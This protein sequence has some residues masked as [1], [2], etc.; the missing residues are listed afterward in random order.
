MS[1]LKLD[2]NSK[3]LIIGIKYNIPFSFSKI[4]KNIFNIVDYYDHYDTITW[5]VIQN[6]NN[7]ENIIYYYIYTIDNIYI[8][9]SKIKN[10]LKNFIC[11]NNNLYISICCYP[12][13]IF[14]KEITKNNNNLSTIYIKK[15]SWKYQCMHDNS[16]CNNNCNNKYLIPNKNKNI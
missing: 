12:E 15:K 8:N 10:I 14:K 6:I 1:L 7:K 16:I 11:F 2:Y 5:Y 13:K 4:K 3:Y 9:L